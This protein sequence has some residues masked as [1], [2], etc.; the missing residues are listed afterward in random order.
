MKKEVIANRAERLADLASAI[1]KQ[2]SG[3]QVTLKEEFCLDLLSRQTKLLRD[4]AALLKTNHE[5]NLD[6]SFIL[7]RCLLDDF[8][9]V[10]YIAQ[11]AD[12]YQAPK[13]TEN[14]LDLDEEAENIV[15]IFDDEK[16]IQHKASE[17]A[18]I[19]NMKEASWKLNHDFFNSELEDLASAEY[20]EEGWQELISAPENHIYFKNVGE[21][22]WKVFPTVRS[23]V[24]NL[25]F[26]KISKA[27]AH[28]FVVWK[29]L[30]NYVHFS[31]YVAKPSQE[32]RGIEISQL[33]EVISYCFKTVVFLSGALKTYGLNH[34]IIDPTNLKDEIFK[35][36]QKP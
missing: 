19:I 14:H 34:T 28:A 13:E 17:L 33:G 30:S 24:D 11:K 4:I 18:Q 5:I 12:N 29:M 25:P 21:R 8:I 6:S 10:L 3:A 7:F 15:I 31:Q 26:T 1:C 36:Y 16:I 32:S 20:V 23:I 22:K 2:L 27:N 35:G 9:K